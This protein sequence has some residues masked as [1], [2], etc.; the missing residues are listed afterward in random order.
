MT[1]TEKKQTYSY[2]VLAPAGNPDIFRQVIYAG[3]DAVYFGGDRFGARAYADNF[4]MEEAAEA[5]SFAHLH[6]KKAY[7][8]VNTLLKNNEIE[9]SLY[10]YLKDYVLAGI[11]AFIV[12]DPGVFMMI[13][14]CFPETPIHASTQMT[15]AGALSA[16]WLETMGATR[17][18][19]SREL[20]L[21]EIRRI[22][23]TSGVEIE[24]FVHGALC[25]CY[26][27]QC[28]MSSMLG[29]RSG[30]RGRCAQP[31][32]LPYRV[33]DEEGRTVPA[34]GEYV[35]SPKDLCG[36]RDLLDML[37]A[38]VYSFKIEGRMKQAAYAAGVTA[39]YAEALSRI[40]SGE[41]LSGK[42]YQ[43]F[44]EQLL[45]LG[46]RNGFTDVYFHRQND[47]SMISFT[48]PSHSHDRESDTPLSGKAIPLKGV[49]TGM[50]GEP[51]C[52]QISVKTALPEEA[53]FG[54][55][56]GVITVTGDVPETAKTAGATR[57]TI[58]KQLQ[59]TGGTEFVFEELQIDLKEGLFIP[60][61]SLNELR[62]KGLLGV[63]KSLLKRP[64]PHIAP[65]KKPLGEIGLPSFEGLLFPSKEGTA[66][67]LELPLQTSVHSEELPA[68]ETERS[69]AITPVLVSVETREQLD[70]VLE[71]EFVTH[72]AIPYRLWKQEGFGGLCNKQEDTGGLCKRQAGSGDTSGKQ[73]AIGDLMG[74]IPVFRFPPVFRERGEHLLE[75]EIISLQSDFSLYLA[76]SYDELQFLKEHGISEEQV[77]LDHRLYTWSNRA[78]ETFLK[79]GYGM[80][81]AP[82]ELNER[83]L[84]HRENKNS[85]VMVYGRVPLMIT[86]NCVRNS[87]K[88]CDHRTKLWYLSDRKNYRFPVINSCDFCYNSIYNSL[89]L[90]LFS[91]AEAV[92]R[93]RFGGYRLDFTLEDNAETARLLR[94]FQRA[95][96]KNGKPA[97]Q[98][99][100]STKGHFKRG[101]E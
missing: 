48:S 9:K 29:G 39:V 98:K 86:A 60:V 70:A 66:P 61:K 11:D 74:K 87:V 84:S 85:F 93:L 47:A 57:E 26:S 54:E 41:T 14:D 100:E 82:L 13:R 3:A 8:T 89:P 63:R 6:G 68:E 92:K 64:E 65:L 83:E 38:G 45:S 46:N 22:H 12:Q 5:I 69:P 34:K 33:L 4:P 77:I 2:E 55:E 94:E 43:R 42:V 15:A 79:K 99:M 53:S 23:N 88:G 21:S 35:L 72:V 51:L 71:A 80:L 76:S 32:R 36:V 31:C 24:T 75:K 17:V 52:L 20:S 67:G 73:V 40:A 10:G 27:G 30:N 56:T 49:F 101:V 18:V 16:R 59:K 25:V 90:S 19:T 96:F 37:S 1:V 28:L 50:P 91:E 81:T 78:E 44:E 58:K 95:F 62:R 7:L 97:D